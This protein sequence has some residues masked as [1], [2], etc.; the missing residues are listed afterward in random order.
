MHSAARS[1]KKN[2][3][4]KLISSIGLRTDLN[5]YE[6]TTLISPRINLDYEIVNSKTNLIFNIGDYYQNPP[7]IYVANKTS[8]RLKSARAR[9]YSVCLEHMITASTKFS[10]SAY[11]KDYNN[12]PILPNSNLHNDPTFLF[13]EL[14]MYNGIVSEGS[15]SSKGLEVLIQKKRVENFYGLIG[16]SIFNSTFIDFEGIERNRN[17]NYRYIFNIV[18]GYRPKSD[19]ELS[20]RWSYFGGRPYTPINLEASISNNEQYSDVENFNE[21]KTPD[22]HS[23]FVRYERRYNLKKSNL[24]LFFEIWNTYNR[25]N[26]ETFF[27]SRERESIEKIR[28]FSTI[29]VGGFGIEF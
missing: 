4:R 8:D 17:H 22:Y 10:V 11:Q 6:N 25:E 28:Y 29:P 26:I 19:W 7:A 9:Q 16:G 18:G 24:I 20:I 1:L 23:L 13:D 27:F 3:A 15:A 14:R 2:L 5:D 21:N 12:S